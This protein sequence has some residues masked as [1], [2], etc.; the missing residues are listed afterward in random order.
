[1][2]VDRAFGI[3]KGRLKLII[4]R[5]KVHF[6]NMPDIVATCMVLYNLCILNNKGIE[7]KWIIEVE[8][9]L[10]RKISKEEIQDDSELRVE[11]YG[12][13]KVKRKILVREDAPI[14]NEVIDI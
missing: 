5:S 12:F 7:D 8:N 6:R 4:K 2:Y 3:L 14:A 11:K 9:K 10:A 13:A 1:M